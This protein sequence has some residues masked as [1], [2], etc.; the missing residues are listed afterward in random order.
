M[1]TFIMLGVGLVNFAL[2]FY[3]IFHILKR[4]DKACMTKSIVTLSIGLFF[5]ISGTIFMILGSDHI[6]ISLHGI[7]G[8]VAL[9]GMISDLIII[10]YHKKR[11]LLLS[12]GLVFLFLQHISGGF[13]YIFLV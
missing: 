1:N 11:S 9:L 5:D 7:I 8:Y 12:R 4:R 10:T 6:K 3:T 13:L 2:I